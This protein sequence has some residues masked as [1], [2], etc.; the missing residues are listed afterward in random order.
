MWKSS[1][2]PKMAKKEGVLF[3]RREARKS[4]CVSGF[5]GCTVALEEFGFLGEAHCAIETGSRLPVSSGRIDLSGRT[6][7]LSTLPENTAVGGSQFL[8]RLIDC[9]RGSWEIVLPLR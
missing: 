5:D 6:W 7:E 2:C 4:A 1:G 3:G 9:L 8:S